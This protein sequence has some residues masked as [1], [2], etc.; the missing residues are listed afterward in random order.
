MNAKAI[1]IT[2]ENVPVSSNVINVAILNL[3]RTV[4]EMEFREKTI[5]THS[6]VIQAIHLLTSM[7]Q[8]GLFVNA[9]CAVVHLMAC[10]TFKAS[11]WTTIAE[12]SVLFAT[13][14]LISTHILS[15][16]C[17][18]DLNRYAMIVMW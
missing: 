13:F 3:S 7:T 4:Q 1:V 12:R 18:Q 11:K 8:T 2:T 17:L 5:V 14:F 6:C 10:Q 9:I 16:I 15:S